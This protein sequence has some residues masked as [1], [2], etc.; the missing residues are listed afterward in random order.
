MRNCVWR[1][2]WNASSVM[3]A[4]DEGTG[5]L[6]VLGDIGMV[7]LAAVLMLALIAWCVMMLLDGEHIRHGQA[8]GTDVACISA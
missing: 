2:T 1:A 8:I 4:C 3:S 5:W 6:Q 7:L